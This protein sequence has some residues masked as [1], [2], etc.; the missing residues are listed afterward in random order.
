VLQEYVGAVIERP[1]Q[2]EEKVQNSRRIKPI[3]G[4]K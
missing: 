1:Q 3:E 4:A 2:K